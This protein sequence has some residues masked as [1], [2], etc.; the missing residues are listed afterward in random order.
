MKSSGIVKE[1]EGN[2]SRWSILVIFQNFEGVVY[3]D[4]RVFFLFQ[5]FGIFFKT[6][7]F[8]IFWSR[9]SLGFRVEGKME[10]IERRACK[11]NSH[12]WKNGWVG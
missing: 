5:D 11:T 7:F 12:G 2:E 8:V 10:L 9:F 1:R 4:S 3:Q 6:F